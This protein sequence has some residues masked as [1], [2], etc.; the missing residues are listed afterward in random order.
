MTKR[1]ETLPRV[2]ELIEFL[3]D[4]DSIP[5]YRM[6]PARER[7]LKNHKI[8]EEHYHKKTDN[9]VANLFK[10]ALKKIFKL[11]STYD[12][13]P[14]FEEQLN[15]SLYT[16]RPDF[17]LYDNL[18]DYKF[19]SDPTPKPQWAL[20]LILYETLEKEVNNI[21]IN[22][23]YV[24]HYPK[25]WSLF[26]YKVA[27][28]KVWNE[29]VY[30]ADF[31]L[32]NHESIKTGGLEK[33][34]ALNMWEDILTD[35]QIF[36]YVDSFYAPREIEKANELEKAAVYYNFKQVEKQL[37]KL[38]DDITRYMVENNI[39]SLDDG[40][41]HGIR[42]KTRV[43]KEYDPK[44]KA[45]AKKKYDADLEKCQIGQKETTYIECFSPKQEDKKLIEE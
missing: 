7:G 38:K 6:E 39:P 44:L 8:I 14:V 26:V 33:Y 29:L 22:N 25:D 11:K 17:R 19:T 32:D 4:Y 43:T 23:L 36:E 21:T 42:L 41:G 10:E 9:I 28:T 12:E 24:F 15:G 34:D 45:V 40:E 5:E 35:Y 31:I 3:S 20:Q 1:D 16:G 13:F 27:D 2:S 37:S 18:I 30:F